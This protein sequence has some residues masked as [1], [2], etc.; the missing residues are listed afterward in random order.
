[1]L[2][3]GCGLALF[4]W[5]RRGLLGR[6]FGRRVGRR[7][8]HLGGQL[9]A[10][11]GFDL[12]GQ[13]RIRPEQIARVLASLPDSLAVVRVPRA[14]LLDDAVLAGQI[15]QLAFFG[16]PRAVQEVDLGLAE[17]RRDLF[18]HHFDL[19]PRADHFGRVLDRA[20]SP[21]V[22]SHRRIK[23][24]RVAAGGRLRI[25]E[26]HANLHPDLVDEDNDGAR[27]RYD[28]RKLAQRLR[29][30]ARLQAHLR[31]A[32]LAFDFR[33]GRQSRNRVYYQ[34]V[35]RARLHESLRDL[36]RLVAVVGL[37]HGQV[38]DLDAGLARVGRVERVFRVDKRAGTAHLLRF[39]DTFQRQRG[40]ARRFRAVDFDY[41]P[42]RQSTHAQCEVESERAGRY[43]GDIARNRLLAEL[44][45]RALAELFLDLAQRRRQVGRFTFDLYRDRLCLCGICLSR[46]E[47]CHKLASIALSAPVS[48]KEQ[49]AA[50]RP[51]NA[52]GTEMS[53]ALRSWIRR[54]RDGCGRA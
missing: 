22:D 49:K 50:L 33:A 20:D 46:C 17:R 45:D 4:L 34:H 24:E 19:G 47:S 12:V 21:D 32:H 3:E 26:H 53:R 35:D 48:P 54:A 14:E 52:T 51:A 28:R 23:L 27:A 5:W 8:Y 6:L 38:L 11:P 44:H 13:L 9:F 40:L 2:K 1:M 7:R 37:R 25:P 16:N 31:L 42:A 18:L 30:Q 10:H 43:D 41:A 36:E 29:H 39:R 15:D